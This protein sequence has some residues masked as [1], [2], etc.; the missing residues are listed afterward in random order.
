MKQII[1]IL[2]LLAMQFIGAGTKKHKTSL[3]TSDQLK[4]SSSHLKHSKNHTSKK[5]HENIFDD[6]DATDLDD[7]KSE[8]EVKY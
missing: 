7:T 5:H 3:D 6:Q 4:K 8:H 1:T 2:L